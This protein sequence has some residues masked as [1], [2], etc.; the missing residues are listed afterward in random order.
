MAVSWHIIAQSTIFPSGTLMRAM[1]FEA[2][3]PVMLLGD[4]AD[5]KFATD[6][7][8]VKHTLP[9]ARQ[10]GILISDSSHRLDQATMIKCS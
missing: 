3:G 7:P 1:R 5:A 9:C 4:M 8:P 10:G 2:F 6:A